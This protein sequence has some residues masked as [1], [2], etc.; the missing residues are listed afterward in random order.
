MARAIVILLLVLM[1]AGAIFLWTYQKPQQVQSTNLTFNVDFPNS[2]VVGQSAMAFVTVA[3]SGA[4]ATGVVPIVASDAISASVSTPIDLRQ[5]SSSSIPVTITGKDV[6]DG[7][8]QVAIY[9]QFSSGVG[10]NRTASKEISIN[11][12]PNAQLTSV[13]YHVD[14][15]HLFGKN[16][17]GRND[18][19]T[20]LFLMYKAGAPLSFTLD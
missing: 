17:I 1:I 7:T 4:D 9:V 14:L 12:L 15:F 3:N 8:Y 11:L 18:N 5:G 6:A 20:L 10:T 16:S 13:K 2:I 19:T